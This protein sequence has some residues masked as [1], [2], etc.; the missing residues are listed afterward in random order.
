MKSFKL[1]IEPGCNRKT[2][3][4]QIK[5]DET[6]SVMLEVKETAFEGDGVLAGQGIVTVDSVAENDIIILLSSA[7]SDK[8]LVPASVIIPKGESSALFNITI[9]DDSSC[10]GLQFISITASMNRYCH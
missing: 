9:I 2:G 4:I 1:F 7:N 10:D 3:Q 6:A 5:D 8:V